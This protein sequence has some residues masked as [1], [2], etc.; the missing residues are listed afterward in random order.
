MTL[1]YWRSG[2]RLAEPFPACR[3]PVAHGRSRKS[4]FRVG[5]SCR[6][7]N[8]GQSQVERLKFQFFSMMSVL[9]PCCSWCLGILYPASARVFPRTLALI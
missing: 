7:G 4:W 2:S 1:F 5:S 3:G 9:F 6:L 8:C